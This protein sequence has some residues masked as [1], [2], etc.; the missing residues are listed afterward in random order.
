M[1][2]KAL[3]AVALGKHEFSSRCRLR[4]IELYN[5]VKIRVVFVGKVSEGYKIE[6]P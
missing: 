6:W 1:I 3:H 5:C 2:V 4:Q